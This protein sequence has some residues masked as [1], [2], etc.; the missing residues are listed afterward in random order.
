MATMDE[1][2]DKLIT[3]EHC[4]HHTNT[5]DNALHCLHFG[6]GRY[7]FDF[8]ICSADQGWRQYDTH[9][10]APYFGIWVHLQKRRVVT[11]CEGDLSIVDCADDDHL[12]AELKCMGEFYGDPPPAFIAIDTEAG[13]VTHYIDERPSI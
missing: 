12:R 4:R 9:Q 11:Y 1:I 10:D 6:G 7:Q 2:L 13:T 8:R 3:S 5:R